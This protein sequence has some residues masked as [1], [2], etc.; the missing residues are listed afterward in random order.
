MQTYRCRLY[1]HLPP[2]LSLPAKRLIFDLA[3]PHHV[4]FTLDTP[5]LPFLRVPSHRGNR[6]SNQFSSPVQFTLGA[7][8]SR[9]IAI[10]VPN[11][12][13]LARTPRLSRLTPSCSLVAL[14][15][16]TPLPRPVLL[17]EP[18]EP[19]LLHS[20][21]SPLRDTLSDISSRTHL[22]RTLHHCSALLTL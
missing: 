20:P 19:S 21:S 17:L 11:R 18:L 12:I 5:L 10:A 22:A 4:H 7:P 14:S 13:T 9:S 6:L 2:R 1:H 15:L 3:S 8:C 16:T